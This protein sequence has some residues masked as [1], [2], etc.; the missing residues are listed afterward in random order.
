MKKNQG[1]N[2]EL[3]YSTEYGYLEYTRQKI[4]QSG[5]EIGEENQ[6]H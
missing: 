1:E 4:S 2:L 3:E 6:G 5:E